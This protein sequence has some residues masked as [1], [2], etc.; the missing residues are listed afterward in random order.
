MY[1]NIYNHDLPILAPC[2]VRDALYPRSTCPCSRCTSNGNNTEIARQLRRSTATDCNYGYYTGHCRHFNEEDEPDEALVWIEESRQWTAL[3]KDFDLFTKLVHTGELWTNAWD[4]PYCEPYGEPFSDNT[5]HTSFVYFM[6]RDLQRLQFIVEHGD[7]CLN[8][9]LDEVYHMECYDRKSP[10]EYHI[11]LHHEH[12]YDKYGWDEH[13]KNKPP[14]YECIL[15]ILERGGSTHYTAQSWVDVKV[16][17]DY[18]KASLPIIVKLRQAGLIGEILETVVV[19]Y[20]GQYW[21]NYGYLLGKEDKWQ[22]SIT[23]IGMTCI[24][25]MQ[26]CIRRFLVQ[27]RLLRHRL[28]PDILFEPAFKKRRLSLLSLDTTF[29]QF[30][31]K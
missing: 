23:N 9:I 7:F 6:L 29:Q 31:D 8:G 1:D 24:V 12:Y 25:V 22:Y 11:P 2:P 4:R 3:Q 16:S 26:A 15:Y 27:R 13:D 30:N 5:Y 20:K 10:E 21:H 14:L 17:R 19:K 18:K 28:D